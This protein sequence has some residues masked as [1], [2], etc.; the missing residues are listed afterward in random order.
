[1]FTLNQ[2]EQRMKSSISKV[3]WGEIQPDTEELPHLFGLLG[4]PTRPISC[5]LPPKPICSTSL[6]SGSLLLWLEMTQGVEVFAV[7]SFIIFPS[8]P[9]PGLIASSQTESSN[10][11][12]SDCLSPTASVGMDKVGQIHGLF[13]ILSSAFPQA[14]VI[15]TITT[16]PVF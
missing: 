15:I 8:Q 14:T 16:G 7:H 5:K 2:R 3:S 9:H 6:A 10:P 13:D 4:H 11:G 12:Y 1:M